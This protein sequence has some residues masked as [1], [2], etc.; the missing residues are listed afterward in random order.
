MVGGYRRVDLPIGDCVQRAWDLTKDNLGPL[1]LF[2]LS[3]CAIHGILGISAAVWS[4]ISRE[5]LPGLLGRVWGE[6]SILPIQIVSALISPVLTAGYFIFLK[7]R[8]TGEPATFADFFEGFRHLPQLIAYAVVSGILIV[9]GL[10]LC[11]IPGLYLIVGYLFAPFLIVGQRLD[12][13][14]AME[15][16]RKS[17]TEN[18][19]SIFILILIL[20]GINVAGALACLVGLIITIPLTYAVLVVTYQHLFEFEVAGSGPVRIET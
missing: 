18:L 9:V 15:T 11:I 8:L 19:G 7:K 1:I 10:L 20:V 5:A 2:T 13:W 14:R 6:L 3:I 12:F 17:V 16:S 4:R